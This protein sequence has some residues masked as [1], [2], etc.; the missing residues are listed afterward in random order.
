MIPKITNAT[1]RFVLSS[2]AIFC[3]FTSLTA[4]KIKISTK[5]K[6]TPGDI[7]ILHKSTKNHD[8]RLY[9]S[10]DMACDEC[11]CYLS[12]WVTF[13]LFTHHPP[14]HPNSQKNEN[15]KKKKKKKPGDII[16]LHMCTKTHDH[17]LYYSWDMVRDRCNCC[18]SFWA[19]DFPF[20]PVTAQKIKISKTWK[21]CLEISSFYTCIPKI[22]I[23]WC[24]VPE[25]WCATGRRTDGWIEKVTYRGGCHTQKSQMTKDDKVLVIFAN[26]KQKF[27]VS[28][29]ER[30][31]F[32]S[33]PFF[34]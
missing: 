24:T 26:Q 16:I 5:M 9:C 20:T 30:W 19:F 2:W 28:K 15:S 12:F 21:K 17:M 34:K 8:H 7:I 11:N 14:S 29:T 22:M 4:P 32:H 27:D 33:A 10:W 3:P 6:K 31:F 25:I 1:D 13:C 23:R 18:F